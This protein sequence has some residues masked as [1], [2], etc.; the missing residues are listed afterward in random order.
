MGPIGSKM[1]SSSQ[2]PLF[3]TVTWS[4]C[5]HKRL[6][7]SLTTSLTISADIPKTGSLLDRELLRI[8]KRDISRAPLACGHFQ[9]FLCVVAWVLSSVFSIF[10]ITSC[11]DCTCLQHQKN[12][13][14]FCVKKSHL[15]CVWKRIWRRSLL[16]TYKERGKLSW[17]LGRNVTM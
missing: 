1:K 9:V 13:Q 6:H 2:S 3:I 17:F 11:S 14:F 16:K 7:D 15:P 4:L 5:I 10:C 8:L 12:Y